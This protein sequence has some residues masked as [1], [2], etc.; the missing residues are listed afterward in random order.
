MQQPRLDLD[1][2]RRE[3]ISLR[4]RL[5]EDSRDGDPAADVVEVDQS[6]VGRLSRMDALLGQA[7][8][9]ETKRRR[10]AALKRIAAALGRI[11]SGD[12]GVCRE[13]DEPIASARLDF[14]PTIT[15]CVRCAE[16]AESET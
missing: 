16:R 6:R 10:A 9:K 11:E 2:F 3:L 15:L 4:E 1:H 5:T 12:F 14:D 7:M 13:C 8:S